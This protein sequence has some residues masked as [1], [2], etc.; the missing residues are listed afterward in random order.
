MKEELSRLDSIY[1]LKKQ[2]KKVWKDKCSEYSKKPPSHIIKQVPKRIIVIGDLHGDYQKTIEMLRISK[3]IDKDKNWIGGDTIVVQLGDQ[4]D[5]CRL[6]RGV[7][8]NEGATLNDEASDMKILYLMTE[9]HNQ[10]EKLGGAVYSIMGN[11]E[12]MNVQGDFRYVSRKNILEFSKDGSIE[13]G[14][15]ERENQFKPGNKIANFLACTR[16]LSLVIGPYLF[17]HAGIVPEIAKNYNVNDM[18]HILALYLFDNLDGNEFKDLLVSSNSP[19]WNRTIGNL[20][21]QTKIDNVNTYCDSLFDDEIQS[22]LF[23]SEHKIKRVFVGHTPQIF[24]GINSTCNNRVWYV[25][26]GVSKAFDSFDNDLQY[27]G[28]IS[29]NRKSQVIEILNSN[30]EET[31]NIIK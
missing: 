10:A 18:N 3:L 26:I 9:L 16:L 17:V 19:M 20:N 15:K 6:D 7:C 31:I 13:S 29:E 22:N 24:K 2:Y 25:D 23:G 30:G 5:R 12:L 11:H 28:V 8:T 27:K 21:V 14:M 1:N 4:I